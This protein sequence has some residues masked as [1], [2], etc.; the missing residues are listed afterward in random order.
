[1]LDGTVRAIDGD[2]V[3]VDDGV[4][5]NADLTTNGYRHSAWLYA[6][7]TEIIACNA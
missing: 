3:Q 6:A 5:A 7:D 4:P 1:M 2:M